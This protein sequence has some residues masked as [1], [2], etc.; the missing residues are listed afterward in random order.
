MA[1]IPEEFKN[2]IQGELNGMVQTLGLLAAIGTIILQSYVEN[3]RVD[4][5]RDLTRYPKEQ[6]VILKDFYD[7]I[8]AGKITFQ[9]AKYV[10][11]RIKSARE[12]A[13]GAQIAIRKDNRKAFDIIINANGELDKANQKLKAAPK[14]QRYLNPTRATILNIRNQ[15]AEYSKRRKVS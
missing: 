6:R 15:L 9:D 3:K 7:E 8:F 2:F 11:E 5:Y 13:L 12:M 4:I 14:L 1:L 10:L